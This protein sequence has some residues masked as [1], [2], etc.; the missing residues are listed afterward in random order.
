MGRGERRG[1]SGNRQ[2]RWV[3]RKGGGGKNKEWESERG[4]GMK[5]KGKIWWKGERERCREDRKKE[6]GDKLS[7]AGKS[8][9]EKGKKWLEMEGK[10]GGREEQGKET[11]KVGEERGKRGD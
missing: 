9:N 10:G 3:E 5:V 7:L 6:K 11:V 8:E 1:G 2:E 4:G